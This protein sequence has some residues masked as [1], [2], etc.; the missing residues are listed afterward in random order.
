MK[1]SITTLACT[2]VVAF[3]ATAQAEIYESKDA[4]GNPVFTDTPTAG[5]E[6]VDLPQE[7][8]AES[9]ELT[10]EAEAAKASVSSSSSR[11]VTGQ[12]TVVE[13][14]NARNEELE[15]ALAEDRPHEVLDA[16]KRYEAGDNPTAEEIERREAAKK[17]EYIDKHGNTVRVQHRG[18]AR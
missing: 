18:H 17:G 12:G 9:V 4:E 14:P 2:L 7:N 10:P 5:A 8:I 11:E 13:I 6:K 15:R 1:F 16:E 3:S